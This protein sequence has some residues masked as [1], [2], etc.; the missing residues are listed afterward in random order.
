MAIEMPVDPE[1]DRFI[2][3]VQMNED[4]GAEVELLNETPDIEEMADGSAVVTMGEEFKGPDESEDFYENL[5]ESMEI[6]DMDSIGL[7]YLDLLEKDKQARKDRDKQYEDGL[8]R[9]GLGNDAPGGA[10]FEGASKVVHPA[11]AEACVD[12][13]ARAVK[14]LFPPDGPVRTNILGDVNDEKQE[15]AER[16]RDYMNW[17]LTDQIE[18]F[19][20]EQEQMLTQLPMGGSQF[21]KLYWDDKLKRP[22]AQ[23]IP[24]DNILMPF[25]AINFYTAPR[26]TE[27]EDISEWEFKRR[28]DRGLYRDI[29]LYR[30]SLEPEPTGPEKANQKIEGKQYQDNEDNTRRVFTVYTW[31]ELEDDPMTKGESAPYILMID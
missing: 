13:A 26:I 19:R 25:A 21:L 17:Q 11:M 8:R 29:N 1:K 20:D 16:K 7:R 3:G 6:I 4:G 15:V 22:C 9:T 30:T 27:M 24:I 14:E 23:F 28:V 12:F 10:E 5:A 31:L 18:E 2:E